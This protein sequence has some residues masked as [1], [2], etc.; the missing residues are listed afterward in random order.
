M[1][2][3]EVKQ[4]IIK[5]MIEVP[6]PKIYQ[7]SLT[8]EELKTIYGLVGRVTGC[9]NKSARKYSDSIYEAIQAA[10]GKSCLDFSYYY[11]FRSDVKAHF[12]DF[13]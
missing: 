6:G 3:V 2:K 1:A 4:E 7:L 5:K 10:I 13:K 12:E 9:S 11:D 8:E